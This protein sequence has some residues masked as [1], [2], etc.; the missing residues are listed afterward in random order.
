MAICSLRQL[1]DV[2]ISKSLFF[3]FFPPLCIVHFFRVYL[4]CD[5]SHGIIY[6]CVCLCAYVCVAQ[7]RFC[8]EAESPAVQTE[9]SHQLLE[10][11]VHLWHVGADDR[12]PAPPHRNH[13]DTRTHT[14]TPQ[15]NRSSFNNE[16]WFVSGMKLSVLAGVITWRGRA[17]EVLAVGCGSELW[18]Q[19]V[20]DRKP[21]A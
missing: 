11:P 6:I 13:A 12:W 9:V 16:L 5:L 14:Q 1:V 4:Q 10:A 15:H 20:G 7:W 3:F 21:L 18:T 19:Y 8:W 2:S 17:E